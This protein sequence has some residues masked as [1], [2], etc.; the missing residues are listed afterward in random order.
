MIA[1]IIIGLLVLLLILLII[2][3]LLY[4]KYRNNK[5]N[6]RSE[7]NLPLETNSKNHLTGTSYQFNSN[8]ADLTVMNTIQGFFSF[9]AFFSKKLLKKKKIRSLSPRIFTTSISKSSKERRKTCKR[10]RWMHL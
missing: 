4:R 7:V 2:G 6:N 9:F 1:G 5:P 8:I 10:W 3:F